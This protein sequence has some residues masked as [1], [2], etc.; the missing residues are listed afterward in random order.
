MTFVK[1]IFGYLKGTINYGIILNSE[2][3]SQAQLQSSCDSDCAG[4][5]SERKARSR[6]IVYYRGNPVYWARRKQICV[7]LSSAKA[8]YIA[9]SEFCQKVKRISLFLAVISEIDANPAPL[10]SDN[11]AAQY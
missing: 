3:T 6:W 5:R 10:Q 7:A 8:D 1:R 9:M 4:E 11:I 2:Q